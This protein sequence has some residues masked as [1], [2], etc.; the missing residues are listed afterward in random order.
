MNGNSFAQQRAKD[1]MDGLASEGRGR[2]GLED[3]VAEEER[4]WVTNEDCGCVGDIWWQGD[5]LSW[6]H[7]TSSSP[8]ERKPS[9]GLGCV[10]M[11][12]EKCPHL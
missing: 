4:G 12:R 10:L 11:H 8:T 3:L 9:L 7:L 2:F 1:E 5:F 6:M